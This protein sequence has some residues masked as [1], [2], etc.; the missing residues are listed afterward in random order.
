M[1]SYQ[2]LKDQF[3]SLHKIIAVSKT[4]PIEAINEAI[5]NGYQDF[6][7]NKAQELTE[8]AP[9]IQNVTWHFIGHLQRNKVKD[10][11]KYAKWI[12]SVD[13]LR[14]VKEIDKESIKQAKDINILVQ[15]NLSHETQ[16][17]G[18][19]LNEL[20]AILAEV[21]ACKNIHLKGLMVI[22]PSSVDLDETRKIFK[23][24][25]VLLDHYQ[26]RYPECTELSMGMSQ[27]YRIAVEEGSTMIRIGSLIFGQRQ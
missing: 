12:H 26:K 25:K 2:T 3:P 17:S 18:C 16:K 5:L 10:V 6:G 24:A 20:E 21:N 9:H 14:L 4:K 23:E 11:V 27:D 19:S 1:Q 22:G 13:S 15:V 8:K 7:E